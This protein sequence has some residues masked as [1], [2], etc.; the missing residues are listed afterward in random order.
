MFDWPQLTTTN[1]RLQTTD[2]RLT[3][4]DL[5]DQ[6]EHRQVH[7]DDDA[8]DDD[9]QDEDHDRLKQL[10][11]PLNGDVDFV[12]VELGDLVQHRVERA[13]LLA[14]ADHLYDHVGEDFRV[15]Q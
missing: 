5:V 3:S 6:R 12:L 2:Y 1:Y 15:F 10:D 7:R 13:G 8:A 11:E 14:D 4:P 9:A